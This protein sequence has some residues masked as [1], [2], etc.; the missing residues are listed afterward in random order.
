[1][2]QTHDDGTAEQHASRLAGAHL[3]AHHSCF[4]TSDLLCSQLKEHNRLQ[5]AERCNMKQHICV[6]HDFVVSNRTITV[7]LHSGT[8]QRKILGS[9]S[10]FSS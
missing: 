4:T 8:F 1:M 5:I 2:P 9:G 3:R 6:K 10:M 7:T